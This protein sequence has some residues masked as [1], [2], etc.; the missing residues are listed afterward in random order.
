MITDVPRFG[1]LARVQHFLMMVLFTLLTVTGFPQRFFAS[2]EALR[3]DPTAAR[4]ASWAESAVQVVGGIDRARDLH[5]IAGLM[6]GALLVFHLAH[7]AATLLRTRRALSMVPTRQDFRDA[8]STL[9]AQLGLPAVPVAFD[10]YDYRQKFEYWGLLLGGALMVTTGLV[11]WLPTLATRILPGQVIPAAKVAHGSEGLMALLVV[12]TWHI[13]NA[14]L[15]PEAFP[16]DP[17]IF[18]GRIT[19]ARMQHEHPLE[20]ARL[21]AG[22]P[23]PA[24]AGSPATALLLAPI[25]GA[26][27]VLFV[28]LVGLALAAWAVGP[29]RWRQS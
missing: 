23:A 13:F 19:R 21:D 5:R 8:V 2:G 17:S 20:L 18:T 9:R 26:A 3:A 27:L 10:R 29:A 28:P 22:T 25:T 14:H 1:R 24:V 11:L 16:G 4:S 6:F 15:S 7:V 12:A